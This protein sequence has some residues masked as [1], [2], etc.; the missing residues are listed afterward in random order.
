[1]TAI[2][3]HPLNQAVGAEI[4]GVD[5]RA[6]LSSEDFEVIH[7]AFLAHQVIFFRDQD[8]THEQHLD[9]GR[10][11]GELHI[12][13]NVP[14]HPA[15]KEI[16]IIHADEN[17][18]RVE[19]SGWH[20]DVSFEA[21]PPSA[22]MLR[23]IETPASGGGDT[24]F[25]SMYAAYDALSDFWKDMLQGLTAI[26]DS[27]GTAGHH[28]GDKSEMP[29]AEH[30]VIRT[31]PETGRKALYV[32]VGFTRRIRGMR[33]DESQAI[34]NHLFAHVAKPDFQCRFRW[35]PNS[36]A[37]W[38]NRCV[39]HY[40]TWDYFPETRRGYRVTVAGDKPV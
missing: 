22:S 9:F 1:M 7:G 31:H 21:E 8:L 33:G 18:R 35:Q 37:M 2:S 17:S 27:A 28:L 30:P 15:H 13:P 25:S 23:M 10:R 24:L 32:N 11:F 6:P 34:L 29:Q 38:D 4:R 19:G 5:L 16:L 40:A 20:T 14:S 26:H 3:T 36:M 12:H 39:Q